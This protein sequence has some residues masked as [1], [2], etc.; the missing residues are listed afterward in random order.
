MKF[1]IEANT[2]KSVMARMAAVC[3][4][5]TTIPILQNVKI[6]VTDDYGVEF[7]A[8]DL[9][10]QIKERVA[11][12]VLENGA[13]TA[14][15]FT[16]KDVV[17]KL[18]DGPIVTIHLKDQIL[19]VTSGK[20][21]F[22]L[23]TLPADDFPVLATDQ[24]QATLPF[25][26]DTLKRAIERTVWAASTEETRYYLKGIA[27]QSEGERANFVATDGHRLSKFTTE[28]EIHF[29]N[30]IIPTKTAKQFASVLV[31]DVVALH[32]SE[33]KV[34]LV[35]GGV[36][37]LSKL[38]DGLYPDWTRVIPATSNQTVTA[39]S[40]DLAKAVERVQV[41]MNER[42]KIVKLSVADG[43]LTLTAPPRE[44]SGEA[45]DTIEA[46]KSGPDAEIGMNAKYA[47][48]AMKQ[49]DK[50]NVTIQYGTNGDPLRICYDKEPEL[51]V[52]VMP[53]RL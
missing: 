31:D 3:E 2:L 42:S 15:A 19:H 29:P 12:N 37:V 9:D 4:S 30:I 34:K 22:K 47:L 24:F 10:I 35:S 45:T 43:E 16:L 49:A 18:D 27:V 32:V 23:N 39:Q 38:I 28:C 44:G 6:S 8:T 51:L 5:R 13:I 21:K 11:T 7:T 40:T 17:S 52:I 33:T 53:A 46:V 41:V 14:P 26:G 25:H 48:D 1:T 20:S 36:E 50:G